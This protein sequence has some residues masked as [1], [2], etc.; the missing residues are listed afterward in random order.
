MLP[1]TSWGATVLVSGLVQGLGAELGFA[2]FGYASFG[3]VAAIVSGAL[4]GPFAALY[5]TTVTA[6][7]D[8]ALGWKFAYAGILVVSGAVLAGAGGWLI[9]RALAAAGALGA[10]PPG[11]ESRELRAV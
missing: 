7:A 11:Q 4:A 3:L 1:G 5:E 10:F 9:T 8:W 6:S 2:L